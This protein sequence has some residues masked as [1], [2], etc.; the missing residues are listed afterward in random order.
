L[1]AL[2]GFTIYNTF[3]NHFVD[4][5]ALF[6]F[7]LWA[8]DEFVYEGR[9]GVFPLM[10]AVN[11]LNNYFFF[12][13][14][15]VFLFIYFACKMISGEYKMKLRHFAVLT[16]E[17]LLGVA[18]GCLLLL[19]AALCLKDNPRTVDLSSG[20]GFLMY[21]RVQQYFAIFTS[22]FFPPDPTYLPSI[23][24][25]G[26]IK[27]T[28]L[29]AWLP[30]VSC[31]GVLAYVRVRKKSAATKVL[32]TCFFMAFVP[33]LNSAFYAL[34]S[35]YYARWF[36][37]PILLMCAATMQ[38]LE[39]DDIDVVGGIKTVAIITAAFA[40]F[41]LIP[42]K[43]EDVWSFGVANNP[44]QFWLSYGIALAG[45]LLFYLVLRL[46]KSKAKLAP[47]LLAAVLGFSVFYSVIHISLGKFPQWDGDAE[48]RSQDYV[49]AQNIDWGEDFYRIDSYKCYDN[50]GL[51]TQKP[52][53]QFFNSV[54][55]PSIMEFYP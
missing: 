22:L 12:A 25:E 16:F 54:V 4:C 10:V 21:Y 37:M 19:P 45:L 30:V 49:A 24:T 28:S 2:S 55:T 6:P 33:V 18:M 20:F 42:K 36:Y 3:F 39:S 9:R 27:H 29:T 13:G 51:W 5:I 11:L 7:L 14:Q 47:M 46:A 17:S 38:A 50:I 8:L 40:V 26:V 32:W 44:K 31:A 35:S 23:Y 15:I 53:L 43:V 41:G 34:N 48:Y 1:Y 52:C